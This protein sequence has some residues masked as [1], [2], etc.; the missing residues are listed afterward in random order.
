MT[1]R[2]IKAEWR[3][4]YERIRRYDKAYYEDA[5]PL[6]SDEDY[7]SLRLTFRIV[8]KTLSR[9]WQLSGHWLYA[10]GIVSQTHASGDDAVFR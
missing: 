4:L 7:D 3:E 2:S 9:S 10:I 5:A 8:T 6:I 1:I